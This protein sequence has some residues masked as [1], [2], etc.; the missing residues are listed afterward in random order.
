MTG[1]GVVSSVRNSPRVIRHKE[2]RVKNPSDSVVDVL[3]RGEGLV[4]TFVGNDPETGSKETHGDGDEG[5]SGGSSGVVSKLGESKLGDGRINLE[6]SPCE[7]TER[8]HI[9]DDVQG[10]PES[11]SVETVSGNGIEQLLDGKL[12]R[13]KLFLFSQS[14]LLGLSLFLFGSGSDQLFLFDLTGNSLSEGGRHG[15]DEEVSKKNECV[16]CCR[17]VMAE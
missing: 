15:D 16:R 1:S 2:N 6:R 11:R 13:N 10:R 14:S 12:R 17:E 5:V 8:N 3:G 7:N 9:L 4:T